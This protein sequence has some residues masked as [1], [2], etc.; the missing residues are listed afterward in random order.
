[1]LYSHDT[2][3]PVWDFLMLIGLE[4]LMIGRVPLEEF[5]L[6]ETNMISWFSKKHNC[7]SLSTVEAE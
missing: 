1:M 7:V 3:P 4:V 6:W 2:N 5:S